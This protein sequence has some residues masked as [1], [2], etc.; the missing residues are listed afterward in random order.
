M[1]LLRKCNLLILSTI[2]AL[3]SCDTPQYEIADADTYSKIF[4]QSASNGTV[5]KSLPIS[6][7][8][9]EISLGAG[10]G[11]ITK[12]TDKI[13]VNFEISASKIEEYNA[14]NNT[15][16]SLPPQGSYLLE[17]TS[18]EIL[19]GYSGSNSIKLK[20]NPLKLGGTK[21]YLIPVSIT[22][23]VPSIPLVD[24]LETTYILVNGFYET[25]PYT[26]IDKTGWEIVTVSSDNND[27]GVGG[28]ARFCID[29]DLN[30]C[31]LTQYS[32]VNGVRPA[33]PHHIVIDMKSEKVMHGIQLFGRK[34]LVGASSQTYLFPKTVHV[35]T[36]SNGTD[37]NSLGVFTLGYKDANNPEDTMYFEQSA[38][39]RYFKVTIL[40]STSAT[41][42]TSGIAELIP[43]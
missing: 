27:N 23:V 24:G 15:N 21:P 4:M 18:A 13:S 14:Q 35:E 20:I 5:T 28:R 19:P 40:G 38:T 11:G 2:I 16:Y 30:T 7:S 10:Y 8:W 26:P 9:N 25:N 3:S 36:S 43:F 6:D 34:T 1:N 33:H 32:R 39:C 42:D 22:N 17:Q 29:G 31:W 12:M 41:G 37:W